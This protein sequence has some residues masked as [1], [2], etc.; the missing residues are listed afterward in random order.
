MK[1]AIATTLA[2]ATFALPASADAGGIDSTVFLAAIFA[3]ACFV[4]Y[5]VVWS[6]TPALHTPLM[7][8]M[9]AISSVIVVGALVA[10]AAHG[11]S[12]E[13]WI[14]KILGAI[15]VMLASVNIFGGFLVTQRMLAMYKKKGQ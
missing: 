4:G 15:A 10:A 13:G 9:N 6:V 7:A 14:A 2:L 12:S 8:V 5:Y 11:L 1:R 3:L